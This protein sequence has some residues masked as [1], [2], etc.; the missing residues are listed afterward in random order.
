VRIP[1]GGIEAAQKPSSIRE[2]SEGRAIDTPLPRLTVSRQ[3]TPLGG[4]G[5]GSGAVGGRE[6][7]RSAVFVCTT[8]YVGVD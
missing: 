1:G 7:Q 2:V 6:F 4:I 3:S 8:N 5:N